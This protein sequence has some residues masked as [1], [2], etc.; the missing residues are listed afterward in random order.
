MSAGGTK[1]RLRLPIVGEGDA[2]PG[3]EPRTNGAG[4]IPRIRVLL[5][6]DDA[7][8]RAAGRH[9]LESLGARVTDAEDAQD[10]LAKLNKAGPFDLL[11][12]DIVMPGGFD[13]RWLAEQAGQF[14]PGLRVLF[15]SGY[16]QGR[17]DPASL[18]GRTQAFIA[19]PYTRGRLASEIRQLF[20]ELS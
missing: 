1:F 13:G 11:F 7:A 8:L 15:T 19:K 9:V 12:T 6:E 14:Q 2:A 17:I 16:A 4:T 18:D 10:G 3:W 20:P 5:V